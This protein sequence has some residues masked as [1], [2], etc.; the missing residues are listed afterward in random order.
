M[1]TYS[2]T[3]VA[4]YDGDTIRANI[5]LGF[6]THIFK[7]ELRLHGINAPEMRGESAERGILARDAL[8]NLI[9]N[10]QVVITTHKD[11]KEKYG[12]YL[13]EITCDGI[14]VNEWLVNNGYAVS[15][16]VER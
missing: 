12:R 6:S 5:D 14:Y 7:A 11:R 15:Y 10:K 13:A 9:L 4:V 1:F 3:I 2:A 16:M 8:R